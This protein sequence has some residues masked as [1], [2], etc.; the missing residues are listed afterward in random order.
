MAKQQKR[1]LKFSDEVRQ[2]IAMCGKSRREIARETG[3][4]P[5]LLTRYVQSESGLSTDSLDRLA[6]F[7][8]LHVSDQP[9]RFSRPPRHKN[10][11]R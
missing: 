11:G 4:D 6:A 5:A 2:A 8:G 7:L 9:T 3:I 10:T 1:D